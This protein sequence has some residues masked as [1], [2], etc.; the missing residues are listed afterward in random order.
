MAKGDNKPNVYIP[1]LAVCV[2]KRTFTAKNTQN[3]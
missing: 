1:F 3:V 2:Q